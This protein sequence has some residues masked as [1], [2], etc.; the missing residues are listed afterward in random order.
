MKIDDDGQIDALREFIPDKFH[1]TEHVH[2]KLIDHYGEFVELLGWS[3]GIWKVIAAE[4]GGHGYD[5]LQGHLYVDL[6]GINP[7][8]KWLEK[9]EIV[10]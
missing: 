3:K 7:T 2:G 8:E 1:D 4:T 5:I 9:L 10:K 6:L